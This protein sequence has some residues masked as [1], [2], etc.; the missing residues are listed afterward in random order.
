MK[1]LPLFSQVD[2]WR[3][4]NCVNGAVSGFKTLR[5]KSRLIWK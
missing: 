2:S 4:L 3:N 5:E 1:E